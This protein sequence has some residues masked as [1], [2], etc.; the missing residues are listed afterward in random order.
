MVWHRAYLARPS[1]D[2]AV[3]SFM[4]VRAMRPELEMSEVVAWC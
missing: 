1:N 4:I 3:V 2:R